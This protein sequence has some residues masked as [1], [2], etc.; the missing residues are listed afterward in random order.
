MQLVQD[1]TRRRALIRDV[2]FPYLLKLDDTVGYT[3][4]FIQAFSALITGTYEAQAKKTTVGMLLPQIE[5]RLR[6][7]FK[8]SDPIQVKE[9]ERYL[10]LI[11][12]MKDISIQDMEYATQLPR[13][14]DGFMLQDKNKEKISVIDIDKILG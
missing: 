3:K 7:I 13:Y 8:M 6:E 10:G 5:T 14:I 1:T 12:L 4:V 9:F 11:E 2:I